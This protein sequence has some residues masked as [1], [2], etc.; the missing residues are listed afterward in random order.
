[1]PQIRIMS[2]VTL[3]FEIE[4]FLNFGNHTLFYVLVTLNKPIFPGI[5]FLRIIFND[6]TFLNIKVIFLPFHS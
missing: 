1:M 4:L 3:I 6:I 5:S 2:L